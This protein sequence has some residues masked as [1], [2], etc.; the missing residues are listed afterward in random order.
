MNENLEKNI[1]FSKIGLLWE[2]VLL[3]Y[4][5]IMYGMNNKRK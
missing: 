1:E 5:F 3:N 2:K 4:A